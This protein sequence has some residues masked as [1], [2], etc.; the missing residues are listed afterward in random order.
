MLE[1]FRLRWLLVPN[2]FTLVVNR[3]VCAKN[4]TKSPAAWLGAA[5]LNQVFLMMLGALS[6]AV[7]RSIL[8][9]LLVV[10]VGVSQEANK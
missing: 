5:R 10:A 2:W 6:F 4:E 9:D 7:G 8:F 1:E 3:S